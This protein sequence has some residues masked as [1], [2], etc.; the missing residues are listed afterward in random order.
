[1]NPL[2]NLLTSN[3]CFN[4][5]SCCKFNLDDCIDA[6]MFSQTQ[7][8][9][10]LNEHDGK[11]IN[12]DKVGV[13]LKIVLNQIPGQKGRFVCPLYDDLSKKCLV[14]DYRPFDC[15][16]W[17]FYIMKDQDRIVIAL[18]M[19]CPSVAKRYL[20]IEKSVLEEIISYMVRNAQENPDLITNYL[21]KHKIILDITDRFYA[22]KITIHSAK[23]VFI[24][25][26]IAQTKLT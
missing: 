15:R 8:R 10:I 1:M 26:G 7:A 5:C 11:N 3:D 24:D 25:N 19:D 4:C 21:P 9:R 2:K 20:T 16:T 13:L 17:P 22:G 14:Y 6:P 12:F 23:E 18:T